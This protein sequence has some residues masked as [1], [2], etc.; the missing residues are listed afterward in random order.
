ISRLATDLPLLAE[1]RVSLSE[2]LG[3]V[4]AEDVLAPHPLPPFD[5]SAMDGFALISSD[6]VG[7]SEQSPVELKIVGEVAAGR[8]DLPEIQAGQAAR[9]TTGAPIPPG[10]DCVVPV[11]LTD[12]PRPMAGAA[13][14][15]SIEVIQQVEAGDYVRKAGLDIGAGE[16]LLEKGR[17]LRPQD[18]GLLAAVGIDQ[19][20]VRRKP[21]IAILSTGDEVIPVDESLQ[22]GMIRDANGHMLAAF[23]EAQG[24]IPLR[25]GIASDDREAV[26]VHLDSALEQGADLIISSAGVSMGAHDYVRLVMEEHGELSFWKVNVRPGKPL[27]NGRYRGRPFIGLP[28]NPVSAWVT[29][30]L[31]VR[32]ALAQMLGQ[33]KPKPRT[34]TATLDESVDSDGRES[35][36]RV[37]LHKEDSD[38]VARLTGSQDSAV[39]SSLAKADGLMILPSGVE[40]L[41]AGSKVQVWLMGAKGMM[42]VLD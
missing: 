18:I 6:L 38:Y 37:K 15:D 42:E 17:R 20:A 1:E 2:A 36:L 8:P 29:F 26:R 35:Y 33:P 25:L 11:E 21:R 28:G 34:I 16:L 24:G 12:M 30:A 32:P 27:A 23:I 41:T 39:L 10:A 31:F 19:P 40:H 9:I 14:P 7:V 13:L 5:H 4:L 22:P 3:R